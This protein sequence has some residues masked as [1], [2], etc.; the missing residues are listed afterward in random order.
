MY[1]A[2]VVKTRGD[3]RQYLPLLHLRHVMILVNTLFAVQVTYATMVIAFVKE[4][5]KLTC[6][7][8]ETH[9]DMENLI[10]CSL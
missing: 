9:L 6:G 1:H 10:M 8:V 3:V 4:N 2:F 5:D 7:H